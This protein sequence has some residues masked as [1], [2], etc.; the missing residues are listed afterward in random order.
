MMLRTLLV[1][2]A[3]GYCFSPYAYGS[4][5]DPRSLEL[6]SCTSTREF[7]TTLNFLRSLKE[8]RLSEGQM[9]EISE[10]VAMG[11][12]GAARRFIRVVQVLTRANVGAADAF[13]LGRELARKDSATAD[14]FV[15]VFQRAYLPEYLDLG[16]KDSIEMAKV[17][18]LEFK[19][20]AL[21]V[22]LDFTRL[23][24]FCI[25]KEGLGLPKPRCGAWA[26][27]LA[28]KG[29]PY[30]GGISRAYMTTFD[31]LT[32]QTDGPKMSLDQ[33]MKIS[34]EML[35][36]GMGAQDNFFKAYQFAIS[37]GGLNYDQEK[38]LAF[39]QRMAK[40]TTTRQ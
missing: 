6:E 8:L 7:V 10:S 24:S 12:S 25:E 27:Q 19:G 5:V 20:N 14:T 37:K 23:L 38:A 28:K 31:F 30:S 9:E 35:G 34:E 40:L 36:Y 26:A 16:L 4:K 11:C 29:E 1:L 21:N 39:A 3:I 15:L 22:G 33:G 18:S 17:L 2:Y 13:K 32:K